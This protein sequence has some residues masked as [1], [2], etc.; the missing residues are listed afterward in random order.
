[1]ASRMDRVI[2]PLARY[3]LARQVLDIDSRKFSNGRHRPPLLILRRSPH[4]R[5]ECRKYCN[6]AQ[7]ATPPSNTVPR[8]VPCWTPLVIVALS[9]ITTRNSRS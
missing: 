4:Q 2:A 5:Y 7:V 6:A 8:S 3:C 1:M 9:R